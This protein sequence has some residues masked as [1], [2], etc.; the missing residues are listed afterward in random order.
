MPVRSILCPVDLNEGSH[1]ALATASVL[2]K[3]MDAVLHIMYVLPRSGRNE[4]DHRHEDILQNAVDQHVSA[5]V[6]TR[7]TLLYGDPVDE[8]VNTAN[9]ISADLIVMAT[10]SD[11]GW[12]FHQNGVMAEE[13]AQLVECPVYALRISDIT[14]HTSIPFDY[15]VRQYI[16]L[17]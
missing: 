11:G 5:E 15:F 3:S 4:S 17:N 7:L 16:C 6:R 12:E 2:A 13:V 1:I 9:T 10:N 8:I 14:N